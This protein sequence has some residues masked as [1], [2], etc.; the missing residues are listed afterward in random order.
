MNKHWKRWRIDLI[1]L[2]FWSS[3]GEQ[4]IVFGAI[5]LEGVVFLSS[6]IL[7]SSY[8]FVHFLEDIEI[9]LCR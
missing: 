6:D 1:A 5:T 8:S 7:L 9:L 2:D 3:R 4:A